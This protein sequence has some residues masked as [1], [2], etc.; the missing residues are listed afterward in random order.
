MAEDRLGPG[1]GPG[2][3]KLRARLEGLTD[4]VED[5]ES[6]AEPK[7][8]QDLILSRWPPG[9]RARRRAMWTWGQQED[10]CSD[11]TA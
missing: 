6:Q 7:G 1:P 3:I 8:L 10:G 2:P 5:G 9:P 11:G 4:R